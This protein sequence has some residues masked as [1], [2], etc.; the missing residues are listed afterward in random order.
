[1]SITL[2]SASLPV[3][4]KFLGN[5]RHILNKAQAD[6]AA[7]G[8]DEQALVQYRLAPDMLPFKTQ[9]CIACDAAKL[10]VAR[11]TGMDAPK[12]DNTESTLGELITRIDNTLAWLQTVPPNVLD[13]LEDK[14]ITFPVGKNGSRTMRAEDYVKTWAL[15]NMFFHITTAYAIL[16]HNGVVIGK[17]DYLSGTSP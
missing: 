3:F 15:S 1:M 4:T 13:G 12:F 8:Y 2:S 11:I 7:R 16:R 9:I 14:E 17:A 6:V 10:C 5:L